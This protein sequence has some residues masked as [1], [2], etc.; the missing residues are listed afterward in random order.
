MKGETRGEQIRQ[1]ETA[2]MRK[3]TRQNEDENKKTTDK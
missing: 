1:K 3:H 2:K